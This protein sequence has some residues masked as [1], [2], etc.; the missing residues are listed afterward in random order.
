MPVGS[1]PRLLLLC[2]ALLAGPVPASFGQVAGPSVP[3]PIAPATINRN[4]AG[5][6]T[7]RAVRIDGP[8]TLDGRLDES[9]YEV[10]PPLDGFI[11]QEP[12]EGAPASEPTQAWIFFDD[13]NVYVAARCYDSHPEREI[14]TEMRRDQ[15]NITQ[16]ENFTV[17]FDTF[18]DRRNG[19]FFQTNPLGAL[20]DQ[21]VIDNQ[22]NTSWNT[23][24]NV[25][26]S[27]FDG[28][29]TVEMVIPFK[30]LRYP[31]PGPQVWGINFRRVVKWKN[32]F[33][34]LTFMPA[35]YGTGAAI[36]QMGPAGT[37]IGL[38]TPTN[39]KNLELKPYAVASSVTDRTAAVPYSND[40]K[41][42]GGFDFKYGLTRGLIADVT[43]RTDFAQVEEDQQQVN[44]TRFNLFFPEK[45]DFFLEGQG[46]FAFGG[47]GSGN[48]TPGDVPVMFFS[49]QI[50]LNRGL[51]TPVLGGGRVTGRSG[52]YSVGALNIQ[53]ED[54]PSS[55]A[56]GTN[57][58]A[59][60]I[61]RD[62]LRRSNFG[63]VATHR[64][65]AQAGIGANS[66]VGAD[67]NFFLFT[68]LTA[69]TY[70]ARTVT[71][72]QSDGAASYRGTMEYA[73]DRY[74][75]NVEHLL[76]G[77]GFD[78]QTG[79]ARRTDFR[80]SFAEFRFTPRP[81]NRAFIRKFTYLGSID[82]V[83]DARSTVLL[84]RDVRGYFDIA[85]Q[86]SD[87]FNVDYLRSLE[88][89]PR[90]FTISP[91]VV[92]PA[93]PYEYQNLRTSYSLGQQRKVS[94]RVALGRG[95]LYGGTRTE[96]SY[97][98]RVG[99]VPQFAVEPTLTLNWVRLP[100]GNFSAQLISS[101]FIYTPTPR[102]MITSL[103]QLNASADTLTSSVRLRWEY[104]PGS[105]LFVVY[106]D[107]RNTLDTGALTGLMNRSF[108]VKFTRLMRF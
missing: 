21:A 69:N 22:L 100:Y 58:S 81:R 57:F 94:G 36:G 64:S 71:D 39:S 93:G 67:A 80:R 68:N 31:S 44:L 5:Q 47:V 91:G 2:L 40:L 50:G 107:G 76:V 103:V 8:I 25:R 85:F 74:G 61:K 83:T 87:Q 26:T 4:D 12:R 108:A 62:L 48:G 54:Q 18:H 52:S 43:F 56:I 46:I 70:Y 104:Q 77:Q 7:V 84:N 82:Y 15:N 24:W 20:R 75:F 105:E 28:G 102:M 49:R 97:S 60:R 95:S 19:F 96:A 53:T 99:I 9:I 37:L 86:S 34:Y 1:I 11:Q 32:E 23:V 3:P 16:N 101:R 55:G 27:T 78:P 106:T 98:G 10:T 30:S 90:N 6:A 17:V 38:E 29:W 13:R 35:S 42:N 65:I 79:F 41:T 63:I 92:V 33:S 72:G 88:R 73:A 59:L 89:L 51:P 14:M 66:L 45:R